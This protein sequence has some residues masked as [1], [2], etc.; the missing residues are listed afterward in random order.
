MTSSCLRNYLVLLKEG[1]NGCAHM[2]ALMENVFSGASAL[3][4]MPSTINSSEYNIVSDTAI[5]PMDKAFIRQ[6]KRQVK[7]D[8]ANIV[9]VLPHVQSHTNRLS[10]L[11]DIVNLGVI[12]CTS[13]KRFARDRRWNAI[14]PERVLDEDYVDIISQ[15]DFT[16]EPA[17]PSP[18]DTPR[19]GWLSGWLW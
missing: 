2:A 16:A 6:L 18:C 14:L 3:T 10:Q 17:A 1:G 9:I 11:M 13:N 12:V 8:G 5:I 15:D 4:L 19:S 7:T